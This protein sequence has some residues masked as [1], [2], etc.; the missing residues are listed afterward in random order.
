VPAWPWLTELSARVGRAVTLADVPATAWDEVVLP[1]VEIVWL[2]GV[3]E[4]SPV[5]RNLALADA[6]VRA[7]AAAVLSDLT[8]E[9]IVGSPYSVHRYD[10]DPQLGGRAG[11]AAARAELARR[12]I[13]LLVDFVPNHTAIDHLWATDHPQFYVAGTE[14]DLLDHPDAFVRTPGASP[15][16]LANGR[17]PYFP[18][19]RDVLQLDPQQPGLREAIVATLVD[20]AGQSDGV[21]C[22]MA[23]LQL[24]DVVASTWGN[25]ARPIRPQPFWREVIE[26]VRAVRPDFLFVAEA[27]W[28]READLLEQGFDY[29]YDKRLRDVLLYQD[30]GKLRAHLSH[31]P[32]YQARLVR[33]IEN[34]DED[35]AAEAVGPARNKAA[36]VVV[37]TVPGALLLHLGQTTGRRL[38]PPVQLGR[39]P[40]EPVDRDLEGWW[41]RLL[42]VL[43]AEGVRS[44]RWE[45]LTVESWGHDPESHFHLAAWAWSSEPGER[46]KPIP[47]HVV[48]VNLSDRPAT[49]RI[50]LSAVEGRPWLLHDRLDGAVYQREGDAM[51]AEG[52]EVVLPPFGQ[53]LFRLEV[54]PGGG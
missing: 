6:Q 29:C 43:D 44:G 38:H 47:H 49:G 2:M 19:W 26:R 16:V 48:V 4:R 32:A 28:D 52:L 5:G 21:R 33:F 31:D 9:D 42:E 7:G 37:S 18:P 30:A 45:L 40:F 11:L 39:W 25:R 53:H 15:H 23:M 13:R 3:W 14:R 27:Y 17:D 1:G 54:E 36:S 34:H 46:G 22:D 12:N 41:R 8:D 24:D 10:V 51:A 20:L 50:R 35:R